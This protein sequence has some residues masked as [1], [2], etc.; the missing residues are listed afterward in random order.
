LYKGKISECFRQ[1]YIHNILDGD[2]MV[3][4]VRMMMMMMMMV[5]MAVMMMP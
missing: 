3:V 4:V 1:T 5:M 2:V